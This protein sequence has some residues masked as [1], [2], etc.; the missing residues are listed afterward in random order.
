VATGGS[1]F[2]VLEL[3]RA[4]TRADLPVQ[5][6]ALRVAARDPAFAGEVIS[7]AR[8]SSKRAG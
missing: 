3:L 4:L 8:S 1:P 7:V 2:Y 6:R 5:V